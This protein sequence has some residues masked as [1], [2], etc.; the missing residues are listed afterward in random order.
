MVTPTIRLVRRLGGGGMGSVWVAEHLGL[1]ANVVVK[2]MSEDLAATEE[3][4]ARFAREA[5]AS[6]QVR[7]PHVVQ[8]LDHGVTEDNV[9]YTV[10]ELLDGQDLAH[11]LD[12]RGKLPIDVVGLI[13]TQL[14]RALTKV[15]ERGFVHRDIKPSNVF[16]CDDGDGGIFVKLLDFGIAKTHEKTGLVTTITGEMLGTP[17]YMSPEQ[18]LGERQLDHRSDLWSVAVL[19]FEALV[20]RRP[21]TSTTA[22]GL[23][24]QIVRDPLPMP[25]K[26]APW[27]P[28]AFDA[29]FRKGCARDPAARFESARAMTDA[30]AAALGIARP[31]LCSQ[32][33]W[34]IA[35]AT[36]GDPLPTQAA[37]AYADCAGH[38]SEVTF[39]DP[40]PTQGQTPAPTKV[41]EVLAGDGNGLSRTARSTMGG[42]G[43]RARSMLV[44]LASVVAV[45][46]IGT[47]FL[48]TRMPG[49]TGETST[50]VVAEPASAARSHPSPT[51]QPLP[52]PGA[53]ASSAGAVVVVASS[54]AVSTS[55][56]RAPTAASV[57][58][59]TARRP[60]KAR[61]TTTSG[62]R[63]AAGPSSAPPAAGTSR[64]PK[65]TPGNEDDLW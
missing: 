22:A 57:L 34:P 36:S 14:A 39:G 6:A 32:S 28:P 4:R 44:V 20:G 50:G 64:S 55:S 27:L 30:L 49:Q 51:A 17:C 13:V 43:H 58:T 23:A 62:K 26:V 53:A 52:P 61:A 63:A 42:T 45:L 60:V 54:V 65:G 5:T 40:R 19:V 3:G 11:E 46:G 59:E 9:P 8:T 41:G 7:S 31:V 10:M 2:F 24:L 47:G 56:A 1:R 37:Q 33:D 21:F 29:W 35:G 48:L 16:L 12:A 18:L 38:A 25:S 15:H